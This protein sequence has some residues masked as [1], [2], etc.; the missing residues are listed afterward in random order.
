VWWGEHGAALASCKPRFSLS[1][2]GK[3][4]DMVRCWMF[5][6]RV[7][8]ELPGVWEVAPLIMLLISAASQSLQLMEGTELVFWMHS[9]VTTFSVSNL[10]T[11][12]TSL[13][14]GATRDVSLRP[15]WGLPESKLAA[16]CKGLN[17]GPSSKF[18]VSYSHD[19]TFFC[20]IT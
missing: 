16:V 8:R 10:F 1:L 7:C 4:T 2:Q 3:S 5:V 17:L 9:H 13:M 14:Q 6:W 15:S 19:P 11:S 20:A 18:S 12:Q